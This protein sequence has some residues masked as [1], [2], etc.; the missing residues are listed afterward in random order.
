MDEQI[1]KTQDTWFC[2]DRYLLRATAKFIRHA[3]SR[4]RDVVLACC[5]VFDGDPSLTNKPPLFVSE[6]HLYAE[7]LEMPLVEA[8][9]QGYIFIKTLQR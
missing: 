3:D 8:E 6:I 1:K 5:L 7:S 4:R 2:E 9:R